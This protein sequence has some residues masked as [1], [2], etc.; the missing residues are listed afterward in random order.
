[1]ADSPFPEFTSADIPEVQSVD[2][3]LMLRRQFADTLPPA[4]YGVTWRI[5]FMDG[6]I[7]LGSGGYMQPL[8]WV[9]SLT[10]WCMQTLLTERFESP[11]LSEDIGLEVKEKHIGMPLTPGRMYEIANQV[12]P[13]LKVHDRVSKVY[14]LRIFVV[15]SNLYLLVRVIT[16]TGEELQLIA[17]LN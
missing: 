3:E 10:Q 9:S 16:D 1:M 4:P 14:V 6:D 5:D 7:D 8:N 13:A 11:L 12:G 2:P 17:G 15:E